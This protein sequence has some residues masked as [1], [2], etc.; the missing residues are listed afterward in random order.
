MMD[1]R[2]CNLL[3]DR[4][5]P[6][7]RIL[8]TREL[9]QAL[10]L[11]IHALNQRKY[12]GNAPPSLPPKLFIGGTNGYLAADVFAWAGLVISFAHIREQVV[13]QLGHE[14]TRADEATIAWMA[15]AMPFAKPPSDLLSPELKL[16][17]QARPEFAI[18][19]SDR[20]TMFVANVIETSSPPTE[21]TAA[22]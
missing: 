11:D 5:I 1:H 21:M 17:S 10:D 13:T 8:S 7:W 18:T 12:R 22:L 20:L 19:V 14:A 15:T 9:A 3:A 4:N 2:E 6:I 16:R